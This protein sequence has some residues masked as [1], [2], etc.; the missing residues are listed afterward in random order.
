MVDFGK[1]SW[2]L[3]IDFHVDK[4]YITMSQETYLKNVLERF[5]MQDCKNATAEAL[6]LKQLL[7]YIDPNF[8]CLKPVIIYEYNQGAI[9]LVN[10]PVHHQRTKHIDIRYHFIR[11]QVIEKCI[12]VFTN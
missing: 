8:N 1:L 5:D 11:E 7:K 6:Y 10:N 2:F 12:E 9:A 4:N 3:G